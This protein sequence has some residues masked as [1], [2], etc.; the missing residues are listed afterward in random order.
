MDDTLFHSCKRWEN[1]RRRRRTLETYIPLLDRIEGRKKKEIAQKNLCL[2]LEPKVSLNRI[3][4]E[5]ALRDLLEQQQQQYQQPPER[6]TT[7]AAAVDF[8]SIAS[9]AFVISRNETGGIGGGN[10]SSLL[11]ANSIV[12]NVSGVRHLNPSVQVRPSCREE[13][14]IGQRRTTYIGSSLS[15]KT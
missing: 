3:T 5:T 12:A 8:L 13:K 4:M 7:E 6:V 1:K 10:T 15:H 2:E 11:L 14:L 9:S